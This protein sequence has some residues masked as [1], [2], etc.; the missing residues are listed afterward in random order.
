M[1]RHQP[2]TYWLGVKVSVNANYPRLQR[3]LIRIVAE[4]EIRPLFLNIVPSILGSSL[5]ARSKHSRKRLFIA[6]AKGL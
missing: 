2:L 6:F 4:I 1:N 5:M 3:V